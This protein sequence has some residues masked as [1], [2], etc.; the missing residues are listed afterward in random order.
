[1]VVNALRIKNYEIEV[2]FGFKFFDES[3]G[4]FHLEIT[5][6]PIIYTYICEY[7]F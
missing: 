4:F 3:N 7:V 1:M 5:N 6:I 2:R